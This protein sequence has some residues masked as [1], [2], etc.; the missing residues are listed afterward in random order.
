M[1]QTG[2]IS[3][4]QLSSLVHFYRLIN[5]QRRLIS[6]GIPV[7][8]DQQLQAAKVGVPM[9]FWALAKSPLHHST[10]FK[11]IKP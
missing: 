9:R 7:N 4:I 6:L 10:N 2:Q 1:S 3:K 5:E 8:L 11:S